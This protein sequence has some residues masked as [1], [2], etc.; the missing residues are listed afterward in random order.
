[1]PP[2]NSNYLKKLVNPSKYFH[3]SKVYNNLKTQSLRYL[4][5]RIPKYFQIN[6]SQCLLFVIKIEQIPYGKQRAHGYTN[7]AKISHK[8]L[9]YGFAFSLST[10]DRQEHSAHSIE[11]GITAHN[12]QHSIFKTYTHTH[13]CTLP[14]TIDIL[15]LIITVRTSVYGRPLWEYWFLYFKKHEMKIN[16]LAQRRNGRTSL[17]RRHKV[18]KII[19]KKCGRYQRRNASTAIHI[20]VNSTEIWKT[21]PCCTT[22]TIAACNMQ[23]V[24][25]NIITHQVSH[26][27]ESQRVHANDKTSVARHTWELYVSLYVDETN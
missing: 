22:T 25:A 18:R 14:F 13:I 1:M 23:W 8:N 9:P 3:K 16:A 26:T 6:F 27:Q 11:H 7:Q 21:T 10:N 15:I 17:Q 12:R 4:F 5:I 19:K 20:A 2:R 24:I